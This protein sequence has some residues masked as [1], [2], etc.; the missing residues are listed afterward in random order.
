MEEFSGK[1]SGERASMQKKDK[2][3]RVIGL[4]RRTREKIVKWNQMTALRFKTVRRHQTSL[5]SLQGGNK[6]EVQKYL[7]INKPTIQ[8]A[9]K[10]NNQIHTQK[11]TTYSIA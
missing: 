11:H 3:E 6:T 8:Q 5:A 1:S 4:G 10:T 7:H 9:M 2:T